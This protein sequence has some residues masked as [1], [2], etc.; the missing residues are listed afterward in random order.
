MALTRRTALAVAGAVAGTVAAASLAGALVVGGADGATPAAPDTISAVDTTAGEPGAAS[1]PTTTPG[2][3]VVYQDVYDLPAAAASDGRA[4]LVAP[5][6]AT[7][8]VSGDLSSAVAGDD[9]WDDRDDD[10]GDDD[11][12]DRHDD[13]GDDDHGGDD[14]GG[15]DHDD[16]GES[17]DD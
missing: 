1:T 3:H 6:P 12:D 13:H 9:D 2:A 8:A 11:W 10:H 7:L 5:S 14:H 16:R 17:W 15:D 4:G